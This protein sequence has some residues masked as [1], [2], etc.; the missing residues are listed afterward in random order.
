M[1]DIPRKMSRFLAKK[2]YYYKKEETPAIDSAEVDFVLKMEENETLDRIEKQVKTIG[3]CVMFF[4]VL[5]VISIV[6]T[7]VLVIKMLSAF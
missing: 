3:N 5:Q 1:K 2:D 6:A 7:I 4:A